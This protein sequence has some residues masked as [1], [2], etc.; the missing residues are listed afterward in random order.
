MKLLVFAHTPP[1]H[2]GQSYM[3]QLMLTGFGGDHRTGRHRPVPRNTAGDV[4]G[5]ECYHVNVRLSRTLEDI[6]EFHGT[7]LFLLLLYCLQAIWCRFRYG[8]TSFYYIPAP[9]KRSA[10]YRDWLVMFLCRPFFKRII[11]HWHAAGLAKWLETAVQ[12]RTRAVTFSFLRQAALSIVLS[13]YNRPDA[14]K[15]F[16]RHIRTVGNGIPDPCPDFEET[17][18]PRRRAR[19]AAR[20]R[21]LAGES[22][23][24]SDAQRAGGD[25]EIFRLLF[26][27]HCTREKGLF[28][29]LEGVSLA[30]ARLATADSPLRVQLTVAGEFVVAKEQEE[31]HQRILQPDL[32]IALTRRGSTPAARR[33]CVNYIG[34]VSGQKKRQA[35]AESDCFCFP[36]YY[37]AE[38]FGLVVIESM[39][40]GMP[41]ITS[42]WRSIPELLTKDYAGLI[43]PRS[44]QRI[45]EAILRMLAEEQ[46]VA[47]RDHFLQHFTIEQHLAKLAAAIREV[48]VSPTTPSGVP[49]LA[50]R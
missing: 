2:H 25:P 50:T 28:D 42:H 35:F 37:Y 23:A 36:T 4:H 40:F 34:F 13:N 19:F 10:L 15:L 48:E 27:A 39:A 12:I 38:S 29:A 1:P 16:A 21:L 46:S 31:F 24:E 32:Q 44:P 33:S 41:V 22:L 14:E 20:Q 7:K 5:I 17:V 43:P 3:T 26:L 45:A 30:N 47:L 8:V 49:A 11:F 9:G 18:L 6:G